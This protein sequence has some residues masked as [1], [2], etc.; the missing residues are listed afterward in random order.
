MKTD[1][2]IN[3]YVITHIYYLVPEIHTYSHKVPNVYTTHHDT[4]VHHLHTLL[5][6]ERSL[7]SYTRIK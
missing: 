7:P 3:H 2:H 5:Q 6:M 4:K 1:K